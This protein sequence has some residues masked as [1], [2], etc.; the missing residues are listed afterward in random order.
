[1]N[2]MQKSGTPLA[3]ILKAVG[4]GGSGGK[5]LFRMDRK[6]LGKTKAERQQNRKRIKESGKKLFEKL[7]DNMVGND[8][9]EEDAADP[10]DSDSD[11][12]DGKKAEAKT[13]DA[14]EDGDDGEDEPE[15]ERK[16]K[17]TS[18]A[19]APKRRGGRRRGR[20]PRK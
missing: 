12:D 17:K 15:D 14:S 8:E 7:L 18:D 10:T 9:E 1:M 19:A 2:L 3:G 4:L 6:Q 20:G 5:G 13:A 11:E 16:K